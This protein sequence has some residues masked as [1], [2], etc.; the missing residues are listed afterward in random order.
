MIH[1]DSYPLNAFKANTPLSACFLLPF[2]AINIQ[3]LKMEDL[4]FDRCQTQHNDTEEACSL[5]P[6]CDAD[7]AGAHLGLWRKL[8]QSATSGLHG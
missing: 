2:P 5:L 4:I 3:A 6:G 1:T 8:V 7:S